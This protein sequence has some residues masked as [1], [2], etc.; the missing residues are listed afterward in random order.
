MKNIILGAFVLLLAYGL[1]SLFSK[2]QNIPSKVDTSKKPDQ[3]AS[4]TASKT[5]SITAKSWTFDPEEI[6]V[7]QND[8]VKLIIKSIDVDHGFALPDFDVKVDLK[9]GI[10]QTI[11]FVATKKG[12]FTFF[13]SVFCGEGHSEMSG[14]LIVE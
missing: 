13:C 5:F 8:K 2:Q 9:P 10:E 7:K 1:F 11:E 3:V 4:P 14:K 12:E 6:R